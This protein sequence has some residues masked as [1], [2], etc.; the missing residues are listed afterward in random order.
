MGLKGGNQ[1][2]GRCLNYL[3]YN[4]SKRG[5]LI[6]KLILF[7]TA[8]FTASQIPHVVCRSI[9]ESS[10]GLLR[11]WYWLSDNLTTRLDLIH[12]RLGSHPHS[13]RSHPSTFDQ[14]S[15]T[16]GQISSIHNRLDLIHPHSA[17]S[18]PH[19]ARSHSSTIGQISY[20]SIHP[21]SA[22]VHIIHNRLDI[23]HN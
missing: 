10:P 4:N 19:F 18:H 7:N 17:R 13:A 16:L 21:Q 12:I 20:P 22:N 14:I 1:G 5:F 8:S 15:S 9:L 11:L 23:I 6:F 3:N 2:E